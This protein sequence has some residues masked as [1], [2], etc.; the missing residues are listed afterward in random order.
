MTPT[1]VGMRCPEC[2]RQKTRVVNA[3]SMYAGQAIVTQA[4]IAIN[5][6]VFLGELVTGVSLTG[7]SFGGSSLVFHGALYGPLVASGDYWRIVTSG[8]LHANLIHI[9]FNM[10][11][12]YFLGQ[13]L[14]P[15]VGHVRFALIYFVS[16]L[17]G[18]FGAL[19]VTPHAFTVGASGAV[20]G[21]A[22]AAVVDL[23]H[24]GVDPMQ[25]G[26]P[27]FIGINLLLGFT[28][29][30]ISIGGHIGGLIGGGLTA[31]VLNEA[32]KRR[33]IP[34]A[35]GPVLACALGAIAVAGAVIVAHSS[36]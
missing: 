18:S 35:V 14:E 30:G 12:L 9:G 33:S 10:Y 11:A 20:F 36:T 21:I 3:R 24:R 4:L 15:V 29:S 13:M 17:A 22:G 1:S 28:L 34:A 16:L 23:R 32:G 5:V 26:L 8:F 31:F 6:A 27:L 7:G 25:S 2:A 19:L